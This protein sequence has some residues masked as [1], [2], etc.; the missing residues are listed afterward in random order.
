M[1][2]APVGDMAVIVNLAGL[3]APGGQ[4]NQAPTERDRLKFPGSS[5]AVAKDVAAIAPTPGIG[6]R[7]R[8]AWF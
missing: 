8:Q 7:M 3:V 1:A 5:I 4:A 2:I 6:M